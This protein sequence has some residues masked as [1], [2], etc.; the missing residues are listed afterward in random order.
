MAQSFLRFSVVAALLLP[1][2]K[3]LRASFH[4]RTQIL[5]LPGASLVHSEIRVL[6]QNISTSVL[7]LSI[8]LYCE[9]NADEL[10]DL[11]VLYYGTNS[12]YLITYWNQTILGL[13]LSL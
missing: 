5:P 8:K 9:K 2:S 1:Q 3:H 4:V 10:S 12:F 6:C 13:E 11:A 7:P